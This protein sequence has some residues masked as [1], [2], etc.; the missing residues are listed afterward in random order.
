MEI[1]FCFLSSFL[2]NI[3]QTEPIW[4]VL[5]IFPSY[6]TV[7]KE[8]TDIENIEFR[9]RKTKVTHKTMKRFIIK[10]MKVNR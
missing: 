3:M 1:L 4:C 9:F 10:K 6:E 2:D 7:T 8:N 5:H